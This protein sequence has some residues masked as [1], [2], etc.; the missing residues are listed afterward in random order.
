[1]KE[2]EMTSKAKKKIAHRAMAHGNMKES[3]IMA[4]GMLEPFEEPLPT[5]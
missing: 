2:S 3:E 1:M 4:S 5:S